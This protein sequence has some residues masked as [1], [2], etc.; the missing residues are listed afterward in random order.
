LE[1]K[2]ALLRKKKLLLQKVL[3]KLRKLINEAE[4]NSDADKSVEQNVEKMISK[5]VKKFS[6]QSRDED[7]NSEDSKISFSQILPISDQR[8]PG[9]VES[10]FENESRS[11]SNKE[12]IPW[13][14][15]IMS[16]RH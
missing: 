10:F 14:E 2:E 16:N 11:T 1:D 8:K 6:S 7:Q 15:R 12:A 9:N 13:W 4:I 3:R 5:N